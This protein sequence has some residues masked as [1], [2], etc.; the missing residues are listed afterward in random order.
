VFF[1]DDPFSP[2]DD[3][4]SIEAV[5]GQVSL[6]HLIMTTRPTRTR[7]LLLVPDKHNRS[8]YR[9][10]G[11]T[12]RARR[13]RLWDWDGVPSRPLRRPYLCELLAI[14][15][16][17]AEVDEER[18][19]QDQILVDYEQAYFETRPNSVGSTLRS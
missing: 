12:S 14:S 2:E 8:E 9:H 13:H 1:P 11:A 10:P 17:T 6:R 5:L 19:E 7:R 4:D 15:E 16:G 18:A 3:L